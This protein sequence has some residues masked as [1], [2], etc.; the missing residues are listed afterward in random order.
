[1]YIRNLLLQE[2]ISHKGINFVELGRSS[3]YKNELPA[4]GRK[5]VSQEEI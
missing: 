5:L 4:T 1:M 3:L 2:E